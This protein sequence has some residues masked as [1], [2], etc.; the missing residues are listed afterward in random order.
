[1]T[2]E[3]GRK[4]SVTHLNIRQSIFFLLLKLVV[5]DLVAGFFAIAF[6]FSLSSSLF[7]P[8]VKI[9]ILSTS[10]VYFLLLTIFKVFLTL[11]VVLSWLNEYYEIH[12][13]S[14]VHRIGIIWRKESKYPLRQIRLIKMQQSAL[15]AL[16]NY[17]TIEPYDWDLSKYATMYLVH[18]PAK[19]VKILESL[20]PRASQEKDIIR[21]DLLGQPEPK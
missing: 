20:A 2:N 16:F 3:S 12:P 13:D 15:G 10:F 5:L 19:Y 1:M 14:I 9:F 17:G 11:F 7:S 8:Q 21:E 4:I 18:N 6:F